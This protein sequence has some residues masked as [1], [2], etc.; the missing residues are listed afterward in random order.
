M[1]G[2]RPAR[3]R[4]AGERADR[5]GE[6]RPENRILKGF[7]RPSVYG[8]TGRTE[9]MQ[10]ALLLRVQTYRNSYFSRTELKR[11]TGTPKC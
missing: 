9:Q 3:D 8:S 4:H 2:H 10:V 7:V 6:A 5:S 11:F 1:F